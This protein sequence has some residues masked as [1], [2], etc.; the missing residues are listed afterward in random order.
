MGFVLSTS[1][2]KRSVCDQGFYNGPVSKFWAYMFVLS[3][4]PELGECKTSFALADEV[5]N[6]SLVTGTLFK[7]LHPPQEGLTQPAYVVFLVLTHCSS[8]QTA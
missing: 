3:K 6:S 1:G 4:V 5:I 7:G 8:M 2:F